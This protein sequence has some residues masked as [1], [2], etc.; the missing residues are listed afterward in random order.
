[1]PGEGQSAA[2][3]HPVTHVPFMQTMPALQTWPQAPQ[4]FGSEVINVSQP[5]AGLP[6]QSAYPDRHAWTSHTPATQVA[7]AFG[8]AQTLPHVP[9]LFGS[10]ETLMQLVPHW[11]VPAGQ[12]VHV[13]FTQVEPAA[14]HVVTP[15]TDVQTWLAV[16]QTPPA[17]LSPTPQQTPSQSTPDAQAVQPFGPQIEPAGQHVPLQ[18]TPLPHEQAPVVGS[19]VSPAGQQTPL[20]VGPAHEHAPLV[21]HVEPFGQHVPSEQVTIPVGQGDGE[22]QTPSTQLWPAAQ[23][24][25]PHVGKP[26]EAQTQTPELQVVPAG[27]Q[28]LPQALEQFVVPDGQAQTPRLA[29]VLVSQKPVQQSPPVLQPLPISPQPGA[30]TA[31]VDWL[32]PTTPSMPAT[33]PPR[34]VRRALRR[35]VPVAIRR[36]RSSKLPLFNCAPQR[37]PGD[38]I[39]EWYLP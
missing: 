33:P 24:W 15:L 14:Q 11:T 38:G 16:Q 29:P 26:F 32:R 34:S 36:E 31:A 2:L 1:M 20:H 8:N 6:S 39:D 19:Q 21:V 35:E 37:R 13:P 3:A 12:V 7:V 9:Q 5:F 17:Q 25:P 27:Q 23:H 30:A 22:V 18:M 4:L 28:V 10:V